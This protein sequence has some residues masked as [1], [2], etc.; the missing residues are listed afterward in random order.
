MLF[1]FFEL[2]A[3][4]CL[5]R[6]SLACFCLELLAAF[7]FLAILP[8]LCVE[9]VDP[10]GLC[11]LPINIYLNYIALCSLFVL[12]RVHEIHNFEFCFIE[13][14]QYLTKNS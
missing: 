8:L 3:W 11:C 6:L 9:V 14:C 2:S 13:N 5:E 7:A 4:V 12:H 1:Y 10:S